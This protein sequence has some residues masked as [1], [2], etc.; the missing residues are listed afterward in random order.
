MRICGIDPGK[1][2][3]LAFLQTDPAAVTSVVPMPLT[4]LKQTSRGPTRS[5]MNWFAVTEAIRES[6]SDLVVIER[7]AARP[8]QGCPGVLPVDELPDPASILATIR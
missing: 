6:D 2:G 4:V 1:T 5:T 7:Q 3:A 8:G